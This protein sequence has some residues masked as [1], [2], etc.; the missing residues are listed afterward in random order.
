MQQGELARV[1]RR[2][3][4][5]GITLG[6]A[7]EAPPVAPWITGGVTVACSRAH[8]KPG[9]RERH[10]RPQYRFAYPTIETTS[11]VVKDPLP[12]RLRRLMLAEIPICFP[13]LTS[14]RAACAEALRVLAIRGANSPISS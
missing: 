3:T 10:A 7:R 2:A 13:L 14:A 12:G 6:R 5:A 4:G 11:I 1:Y 9:I 8:V